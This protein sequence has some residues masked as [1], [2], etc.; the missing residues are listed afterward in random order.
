VIDSTVGPATD[1]RYHEPM[2][3]LPHTKSC[4][5]CGA[6]NPIGFKL[7]FESDGTLVRT[8]FIPR[9]EHAGFKATVHGG[10]LSTLLDEIMVWACAVGTGKFSYCAELTVRFLKPAVPGVEIIAE[11]RMT[12][13]RKNRLFEAR[14]ELKDPGGKVLAVATGKF[15]P[16]DP[17]FLLEMAGDFVGD[18]APFLGQ[19]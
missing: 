19:V 16:I 5:V 11:A 12:A 13:N 17:K 10:V 2:R 1:L 4:F 6:E 7:R 9:R 14:G 15:M 3:P 18:P 8:T